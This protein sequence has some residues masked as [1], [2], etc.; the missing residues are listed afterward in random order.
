MITFWTNRL[1]TVLDHVGRELEVRRL[2]HEVADLKTCLADAE[3][4]NDQLRMLAKKL[5]VERDMA[6]SET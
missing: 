2:T 5:E 1:L 6:R 3:A 4:E